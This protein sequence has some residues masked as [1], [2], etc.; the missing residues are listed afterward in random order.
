LSNLEIPPHVHEV[1]NILVLLRI[2]DW[3]SMD[4]NKDL[5]PFTMNSDAV[6]VVFIFIVGSELHINF[7]RYTTGNHALFRI[8]DLKKWSGRR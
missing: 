8:P 6:I 3:K 7:F 1:R 5:V 2:D 4:G